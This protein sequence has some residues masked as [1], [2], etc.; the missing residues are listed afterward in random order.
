MFKRAYCSAVVSV[1][2][3]A[4]LASACSSEKSTGPGPQLSPLAGLGAVARNDTVTTPAPTNTGSG[5]FR[6]TV[7]G[8]S[9]VGATGD[10]LGSAPRVPGVVVSIYPRIADVNGQVTVGELAGSSTTGTDGLFQLPTLPAGEYV[11][12]F[13]PPS[14]SVYKGSYSVGSLRNNSS[15]YPWWVVLPRK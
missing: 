14:S 8:P 15:S 7:M 6:G 5:N 12:T 3:L 11:V 4:G 1:L 2:L 9:P 10:T 13:V